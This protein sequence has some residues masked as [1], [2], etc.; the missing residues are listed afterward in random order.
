MAVIEVNEAFASVVLQFLKDTALGERYEAGDVNPNGGGISLGHPLGATGARITATLLSE[1][2]RR[3]ARYGIAAMCIGFGQAIAGVVERPLN[4]PGVRVRA[5]DTSRMDAVIRGT[6]MPVLEVHLTPGESVV[7]EAGQLGWFDDGIE[8]ETT[9]ALA[10][11]DGMWDA[12]KRAFGGGT[13]FMTRYA[14]TTQAGHGRLPGAAARKD[15]PGPARAGSLLSHPAARLSRRPRGRRAR[16]PHSMRGTSAAGLLGGFGFML[17]K[18]E[19]TGHAWI[20]LA[21][22]LSEYDLAPGQSLRVHPAHIGVVEQSVEYELT[23]VPGIKNKVFGGDG[24]FLMRLTGP[25]KVWLQ[26]MSLPMLADALAP[27]LSHE[28]GSTSNGSLQRRR[29]RRCSDRD[30]PSSLV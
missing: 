11:A 4:A 25:G 15:R 5:A 10:G 21:G 1:L 2:E 16:R 29:T 8:L 22:E 23:T 9:T 24:L 12:A 18:L 19:G 28:N 27:Y 7:A 3:N 13:F 17:Q 30:S 20:E 26:S 6:T 14:S